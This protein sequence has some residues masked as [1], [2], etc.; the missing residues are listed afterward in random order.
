MYPSPL[1]LVSSPLPLCFFLFAFLAPRYLFDHSSNPLLQLLYRAE[2]PYAGTEAHHMGQTPD[3]KFLIAGG[4]FSSVQGLPQV[5]F[6]DIAD[7]PYHPL[8]TG[9]IDPKNSGITDQVVVDNQGRA[10]ITQ[11]SLRFLSCF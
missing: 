6:Y 11:V 8:Y 1:L 4:V 2:I 5:F 3:N 9:D 7:D 10:I